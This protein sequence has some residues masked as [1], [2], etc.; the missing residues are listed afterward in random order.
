M[1]ISDEGLN[2]IKN[3]EGVRLKA[4]K[5]V[6][7]EKYW[8]IGVG[9]Y[10]PDVTQGMTITLEQ[11]LQYLKKDV[12]RFEKAVNNLPL[13]LNQNEFDALV[14]FTFNCGEGTLRTL[15]K[16]RTKAQIAE[17]F[18]KYNKSGGKVLEG[19]TKRRKKDKELFLKPVSKQTTEIPI[20]HGN[21]LPYK[22]KTKTEL[23]IRKGPSTLSVKIKTVEPGTELTV[24]ATCT[25]E[26]K[27][28]GKNGDEWFCL[29]YCEKL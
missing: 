26:N 16:G 21:E 22:V 12:E 9:H 20:K 5:A 3:N 1:K 18:L 25:S 23:N 8:T 6:P 10:G 29:D 15:T 13:S 27:K 4:Y 17:A 11:A 14:D 28:W 2:F 24:W 7:T 19:L